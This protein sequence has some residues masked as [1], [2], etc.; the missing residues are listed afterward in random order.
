MQRRAGRRASRVLP[1]IVV[2]IAMLVAACGGDGDGA[3]SDESDGSD[4]APSGSSEQILGPADPA[5]G[6]PVRVGLVSDGQSSAFDARTEIYAA[7]ATVD[8][9]NEHRGGIAGRPIELVTCETGGDPAAGTDCANQMVENEVVAVTIGQSTVPDAIWEPLHESGVPTM[10]FQTNGEAILADPETSF[11]LSNPLTTAFGLPV[12][13]AQDRDAD[14]V[15]FVVID[16]PVAV[17][18]FESLGPPIMRNAGLDY[19][20]VKVPLGTPDL[21]PQMG[22]I[23]ESGAEVVQLVGNDSL[24]IAA[25]QG[26]TA[27]GYEGEVTAVSQCMTDATR[28]ALAG[29]QLAGT[30][31]TSGVAVGADDDPTYQLY[32]AVMDA[33]GENVEVDSQV[34]VVGYAVV[35]AFATSLEGMSGEVTP[36]TVTQAIKA[37]P[38][39]ELPAGAGVMFRCGG[40]SSSTTPALCSNEWLRAVLGP[41]GQP[42][43]YEAVDSTDLVEGI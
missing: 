41:D 17:D 33:Y 19:E 32:E 42:T 6:E 26:L 11:V 23:A 30:Y 15:A 5:S 2:S 22:D 43:G 29:D 38:E 20:L 24:C 36:A 16:L 27:V 28:E 18:L 3:S 12:S 4:G 7:Q 35:A 40:S 9:W 25:I 13:V 14:S 31:V 34:S 8:W 10:F 1:T 37:M 39:A 21:T